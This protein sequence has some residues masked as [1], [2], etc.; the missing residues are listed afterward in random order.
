MP[1][2]P[3]PDRSTSS[4]RGEGIDLISKKAAPRPTNP[5]QEVW[6]DMTNTTCPTHPPGGGG[7]TTSSLYATNHSPHQ[8]AGTSR[9][10]RGRRFETVE[11][12]STTTVSAVR[13]GAFDTRGC[14]FEGP[15]TGEGRDGGGKGAHRPRRKS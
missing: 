8:V 6:S 12:A 7:G 14:A 15:A 2:A 11:V 3:G 4:P 9:R 10:P 1:A 5:E 13:S